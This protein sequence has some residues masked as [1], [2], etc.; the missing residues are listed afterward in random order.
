MSTLAGKV[1]LVTGGS[2]GIGAAIVQALVAQG[3]AVAFTYA[4]SAD[5]ADTLVKKLEEQGHRASAIA[6]DSADARQVVDAVDRT[7]AKLGHLDILINNAGRF[8]TGTIDQLSLDDFEHMVSVNLR[9]VF[10]A[11]LQAVKYL[12]DGGRI[13]SIGSCVAARAW[14]SGLSLYA[15]SKSALLGLTQ[16]IARDLG[17]RRI[18]V[19]LI[20]PG[21]IDTDMNP[22]GG[23]RAAATLAQLALP[24]YGQPQDIA[25]SVLYLVGESGRN[26]TGAVIDV[27]GGFNA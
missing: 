20:Q 18:T 9:G 11:S 25:A 5:K 6:A 26:I 27:D 19:N 21:P 17:A 15:M 23:P 1:A 24:A 14:S 8:F 13:V 4:Q 22:A 3:A 12:P 16:G 10:A 7:V 2:R